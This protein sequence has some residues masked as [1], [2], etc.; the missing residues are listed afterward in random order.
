MGSKV[1][2][3]HLLLL[4]LVSGTAL[5]QQIVKT[6][7][8]FPGELPFKLE[9]GY[10]SVGNVEFF[11]YFAVSEGNPGAD[12]L[13][14]Y[15]NG[16]PGCSGLNGFFY[17]IGPLRFNTTDYT[18]GLPTLLYE[19]STWTKTASII[20]LD[21]PVGAG[22]SYATTTEAWNTTDTKMAKQAD[23]FLR[24]WL[25]EH[26]DFMSNPV[27]L[28]SDSYAGIYTPI[29]A[30][31]I[32]NGNE[33]GVEPRVN[34]KG[35]SIGCPHT[36]TDLETNTKIAFAHR[37]AL[38]SDS[39]YES[40]RTS[41]NEN[42]ADPVGAACTEALSAISQCIELISP[43]NILEPTCAFLSPKAEED[44]A[45]RSL[46]ENYILPSPKKSGDF[47][48]KNFDYLMSDI[49]TN[50]KSVQDAL[51]VR[52]GTVKEFFRCNITMEYT[53]DTNDVVP[54]HKNLTDTGLQVL[55]FSG[56]HDMVIPHIGIEQW[57]NSLDLTID[58]D[59][60]PWF[61]GGQVAGYTRK[62]TNDGYRLTYATLKGSGHSPPEYKRKE[63]YEMFHRWIHYY[64]I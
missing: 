27:Y 13:L 51:H 37:L 49:W 4:L 31:D 28:G 24:N 21:A 36:H 7:P 22:F 34:L 43:Q 48:C 10:I 45:Q 23:Q 35:F 25:G 20:F 14:L 2:C 47:W 32:I 63:C 33:A 26:P 41:C 40:A 52:P 60:R 56:D 58:T 11:Y 39:M 42:Y 5:S 8:G 44:N 15:I 12:P 54:Y 29:L 16:G 62:Y 30:Q 59:W 6:L 53:V 55:V 9:T 3:L 50:Y 1:A 64:P 38:I 57:I 18:G 46:T 19:S 17:Q 61:V